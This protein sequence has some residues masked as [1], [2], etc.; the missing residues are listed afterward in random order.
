MR[1]LEILNVLPVFALLTADNQSNFNGLQYLCRYKYQV[2]F[3]N[4]YIENCRGKGG[5][6]MNCSVCVV[7]TSSSTLVH[8]REQ[9]KTVRSSILGPS[10]EL[11][12]RTS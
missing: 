3:I 8:T 9:F 10:S 7:E 11:I 4:V 2:L 5:G 1:K 6:A 12:E